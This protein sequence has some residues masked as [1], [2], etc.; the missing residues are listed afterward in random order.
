MKKVIVISG[1]G[2]G[3]G[4]E[5]AL[6]LSKR[7]YI[8]CG[9]DIDAE[10][11]RTLGEELTAQK[12]EH[13]LESFD[14]TDAKRLQKFRDSV[15]A[16]H[17]HV[18]TV[19]SN[20]GIGFFGAFEEVDL[21]RA[22]Q[23][24]N[25]NVIGCARLFQLFLPGMRER[26]AGKLVAMSSLVGQIP[27]PFESIYSSSK[28]AIEGLVQSIRFEVQPYNI[29]VALIEPAQVSTGFAAKV[30]RLPHPASPYFERVRRF[31]E[32]DKELIKTAT[33]P[34]EAAPRIV[35]VLEAKRPSLF[36]QVDGMSTFFL[37]LNRI[38]PL[39]LRD[40]ILLNHMDIR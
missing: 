8:L 20:V 10:A 34:N 24:F 28:F 29:E 6:L 25:I 3:M 23:C 4:R 31:L 14:I 5:V 30:H 26:R 38:L 21:E 9:F 13:L 7:D 18:D 35:A 27:F 1:I 40:F 39:K 19:L 16:R 15:I 22:L 33:K 11:I 32:R 37:F 17:G 12:V 2:Q 36:N